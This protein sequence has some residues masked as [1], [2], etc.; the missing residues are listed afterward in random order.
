MN[1]IKIVKV[2]IIVHSFQMA[3][4]Q[5]NINSIITATVFVIIVYY[6]NSN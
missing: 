6:Y 4:W 5:P 3:F 2:S 1:G